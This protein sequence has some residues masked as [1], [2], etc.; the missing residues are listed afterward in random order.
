MLFVIEGMQ[1]S[2]KTLYCVDEITKILRENKRPVVTN[3]PINP[4]KIASRLAFK[5]QDIKSIFERIKIF[6]EWDLFSLKTFAKNNP[7]YWRSVSRTNL[8]PCKVGSSGLYPDVG[9]LH[10]WR[11]A[12]EYS[13]IFIDEAYEHLSNNN[14]KDDKKS[15]SRDVL[16]SVVR[17][18]R[19]AKYDLY[20]ISQDISDLDVHIRRGVSMTYC[21]S[22]SKYENIAN[23]R[24]KFGKWLRG[25]TWPVQF[26]NIRMYM[27][28]RDDIKNPI[29]GEYKPA[30]KV[31]RILPPKFLFEMYD[32]H[33]LPSFKVAES[34]GQGMNSKD[35]EKPSFKR[36]LIQFFDSTKGLLIL[37]LSL[38]IGAYIAYQG[39]Q[40]LLASLRGPSSKKTIKKAVKPDKK[41]TTVKPSNPVPVV[42]HSIVYKSSNCLIYDDNFKIRVNDIIKGFKVD[43]I[44]NNYVVLSRNGKLFNLSFEGLR[45]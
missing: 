3:L 13:A 1:G 33:S 14:F 15:K 44:K 32:S 38:S 24:G 5:P 30:D 29:S 45:R 8:L 12:P 43:E 42:K 10:F 18:Q 6:I 36:S 35:T 16:R 40:S 28:C 26:F 34:A 2:G 31:K 23:P 37:I 4:D 41:L 39:Y 11:S 9:I 25:T 17:Q 20:F 7:V 22:N 21:V 27:G 19:H